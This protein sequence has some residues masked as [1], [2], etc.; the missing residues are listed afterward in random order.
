MADRLVTVFGGSGFI[1]RYVVKRLA[2]QG[3]R[4]RV[5]VRRPQAAGFL[6]PMGDVGQV[7]IVQANV[8]HTPSVKLAVEGA[9][10]VINLVGILA[11]SG[12]Q[13][14]DLIQAEGARRIAA[15]AKEAGVARFVQVSAIGADLHADSDY[16][17]SKARGEAA[18]KAVYPDAAILRASVVFGPEDKL[19]NRFANMARYVPVLPLIGG[20]ETRFQPVYVGDVADAVVAAA[21]GSVAVQ[22]R[23]FELGGPAV[24]SFRDLMNIVLKV[25]ERKAVLLPVPWFVARAQAAAVG[26]LPG[27]PIT[28][29]QV[30]L[31]RHDN[32]VG[33]GAPG[34][35]A[36]G[37][38]P[39]SVDA[40]VPAYL[41]RYRRTGQYATPTAAEG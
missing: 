26:W 22:E 32:V 34:L 40:V 16:A 27:A 4:V 24:Y 3:W 13:Q 14:F 9:D 38:T 41:L 21:N 37:I 11:E 17:K 15:A 6:R 12:A 10:V 39:T 8:R 20:G 7:A 25:T 31:L 18:V 5:A 33:P 1:G 35:D 30:K 19:F 23:P 36:F 28:P 2:K 29:D